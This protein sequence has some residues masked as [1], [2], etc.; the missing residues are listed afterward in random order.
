MQ[1]N[2]HD[3][4]NQSSQ[5]SI[6]PSG[7]AAPGLDS[8]G[9]SPDIVPSQPLSYQVPDYL[10]LDPVPL[11]PT[12]RRR[13]SLK[14]VLLLF[15]SL[16][17][18]AGVGAAVV[19][20]YQG[21]P[22]RRFY[23]ALQNMMATSYV[24]RTLTSTMANNQVA[25]SVESASD[26][27]SVASPRSHLA[28]RLALGPTGVVDGTTAPMIVGE[29]VSLGDDR[30]F[31][32]VSAVPAGYPRDDVRLNEWYADQPVP[33]G[34]LGRLYA[35]IVNSPLSIVPIGNFTESQR[36]E[37][38]K[39]LESGHAYQIVSVDNDQSGGSNTIYVVKIDS[40]ALGDV[41]DATRRVL[42]LGDQRAVG[43]DMGHYSK[44]RFWI[45]SSVSLVRKIELSREVDGKP[46]GVD[47]VAFRYPSNVTVDE[48]KVIAARSRP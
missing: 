34:L 2:K 46:T 15:L 42:G 1:P 12:S 8:Y 10:G 33:Q 19:L 40:K 32:K 37:L 26:F 45:D 29:Q 9:Q 35:D 27:S 13:K 6:Y 44:I 5:P 22:E 28:L 41:F 17:F 16:L 14:P 3:Q 43:L 47:S 36:T 38:L 31:S 39:R 11:A 25:M 4:N 7:D 30:L 18:V 21:E 24:A 23:Q 48:P 20:W